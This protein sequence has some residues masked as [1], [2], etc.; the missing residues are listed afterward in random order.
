M[1]E[2][3]VTASGGLDGLAFVL[4]E[5]ATLGTGELPSRRNR[6]RCKDVRARS[7][8]AAILWRFGSAGVAACDG[9]GGGGG[10]GPVA[11]RAAQAVHVR[12]AAALQSIDVVSGSAFAT[13]ARAAHLKHERALEYKRDLAEFRAGRQVGV[14]AD[15]RQV[16][17]GQAQPVYTCHLRVIIITIRTLV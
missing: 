2:Q 17:V 11:V 6:R 4:S 9:V 12:A 10:G 1:I 5:H 15:T 8:A 13:R 16:M 14:N 3:A 7:A